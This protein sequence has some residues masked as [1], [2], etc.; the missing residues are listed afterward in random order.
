MHEDNIQITNLWMKNL[1]EGKLK[2]A[3][4][5]LSHVLFLWNL[6]KNKFK[7]LPKL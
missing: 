3:P 1:E 2:V 4:V 5:V 7:C 6:L